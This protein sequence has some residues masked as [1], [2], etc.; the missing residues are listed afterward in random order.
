[1]SFLQPQTSLSVVCVGGRLDVVFLV[2]A[3]TD[4]VNLAR[5]LRELLSSAAG[6]LHTIGARD[7][8]VLPV[9][10]DNTHFNSYL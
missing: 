8:Q 2:P 4:R 7:S 1:M 10:K 3:S 9:V 6:S 5:P